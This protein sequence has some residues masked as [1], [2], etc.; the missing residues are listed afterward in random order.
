MAD[1]RTI[2]Q[3]GNGTAT[4]Q[5]EL[6][7]GLLQYVQAVYVDVDNSGGTATSPTLTVS[8]QS[9]VVIAKKQ[10]GKTIDAG[11][12]GSATWAL[13]LDDEVAPTPDPFLPVLSVYA[14]RVTTQSFL[15]NTSA[16]VNFTATRY[17]NGNWGTLTPP[18]TTVTI[19]TTGYYTAW[20]QM[21]WAV[22]G[23]DGQ[24]RELAFAIQNDPFLNGFV[25]RYNVPSINAIPTS[26][27]LSFTRRFVAGTTFQVWGTQQ[28]AGA[29]NADSVH[30]AI[31]RVWKG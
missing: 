19:P 24:R 21:E 22:A 2:N 6:A 9:G 7:P 13:R 15:S 11:V 27:S 16:A 25:S 26:M 20:V 3:P 1:P 12:T 10:Q 17:V 18:Y 5:F 23:A 30:F 14:S 4:Q 28:S 31:S 8:E 29:L